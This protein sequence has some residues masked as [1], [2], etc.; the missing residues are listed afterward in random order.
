VGLARSPLAASMGDA[1][2]RYAQTILSQERAIASYDEWVRV[3][4]AKHRRNR[5]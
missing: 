2:V 3:L 1:G 5:V 4:H